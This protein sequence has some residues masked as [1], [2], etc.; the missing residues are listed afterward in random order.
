MPKKCSQCL[1]SAGYTSAKESW[2]P[3]QVVEVGMYRQGVTEQIQCC[4]NCTTLPARRP[5]R[6][7]KCSEYL[8]T[9]DSRLRELIE[10]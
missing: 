2:I 9:G 1:H 6:T 4:A 8:Q 7:T 5:P 10:S 3:L